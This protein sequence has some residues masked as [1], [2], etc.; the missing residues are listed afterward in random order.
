[1]NI[2]HNL[3]EVAILLGLLSMVMGGVLLA[4]CQSTA[5]TQVEAQPDVNCTLPKEIETMDLPET[6]AIPNTAIPPIDASA[7]T[8]TETA[9]FSLG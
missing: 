5:E 8:K 9:T 2:I 4:A 3:P 6:G 1:M 7:P